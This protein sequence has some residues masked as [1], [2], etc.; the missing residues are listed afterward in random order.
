M[1]QQ[2]DRRLVEAGRVCLVNY[3]PMAGKLCVIVNV[4]DCTRPSPRPYLSPLFPQ[5]P[6]SLSGR[7]LRIALGQHMQAG[8]RHAYL[9][10]R[11]KRVCVARGTGAVRT[12]SVRMLGEW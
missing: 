9:H 3:G 5:Q 10:A 7:G 8:E 4:I 11:H 1:L 2:S 12:S 6:P